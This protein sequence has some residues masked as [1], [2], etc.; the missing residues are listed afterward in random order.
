MGATKS[1]DL[2]LLG[3]LTAL[4]WKI[5]DLTLISS[6]S[7]AVFGTALIF[8]FPSLMYR[9]AIKALGDKATNSQ[10]REAKFAMIVNLVGIVVA[11]IGTRMSLLGT[12]RG[13]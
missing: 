3:M 11:G 5:T 8:V 4:A 2:L 6:L 12:G 9:G 10:K 7:G 13:H 1:N